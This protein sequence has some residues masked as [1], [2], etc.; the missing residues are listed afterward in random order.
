MAD[1]ELDGETP[2]NWIQDVNGRQSEFSRDRQITE[3]A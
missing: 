2:V 1:M 3:A